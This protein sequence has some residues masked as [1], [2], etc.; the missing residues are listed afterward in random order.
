MEVP[1][2]VTFAP[3]E[4]KQELCYDNL[5]CSIE[6]SKPVTLTLAGS[7]IVL[8]VANRVLNFVCQVRSQCTQFVILSNNTNQRWCLKPVIEDEYWSALLSLVIESYQQNKAYKIT[9]K[10]MAMTTDGK[11]HLGTEQP[12]KAVSTISR[13]VPC[14]TS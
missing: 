6:G 4:V 13:E 11:K 5:F 1:L 8:P 10:P 9:Y 14:K 7:C 3:D 2:V 12:P